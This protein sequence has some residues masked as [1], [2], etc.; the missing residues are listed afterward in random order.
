MASW[1]LFSAGVRYPLP[2]LALPLLTPTHPSSPSMADKAAL[3]TFLNRNRFRVGEDS[4]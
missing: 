1:L 2:T 4:G 3:L